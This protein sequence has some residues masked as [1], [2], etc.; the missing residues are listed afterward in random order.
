[1]AGRE[2]RRRRVGSDAPQERLAQTADIGV[3]RSAVAKRQRI[4]VKR[5]EHADQRHD[6]E[7]LRQDRRHVLAAH[8]AAIEQREAGNGH[9]QHERA[10]GQHP[11]RVARDW[12]P[13]RCR[14][15][16]MG[17]QGRGSTLQRRSRPWTSLE[18]EENSFATPD[19]SGKRMS[20]RVRVFFAGADADGLLNRQDEYLAVAD[21]AGVGRSLDGLDGLLNKVRRHGDLEF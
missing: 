8:E 18:A 11:R 5:P 1:M 9:H 2:G 20:Q 13:A 19:G 14:R 4:A 10:G 7:D 15:R 12:E 16:P 3:E 17:R 21:L 6:R